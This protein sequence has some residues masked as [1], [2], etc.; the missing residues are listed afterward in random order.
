MNI[1]IRLLVAIVLVG[2][3]SYSCKKTAAVIEE[4]LKS[5]DILDLAYGDNAKQV[6]DIY[7][8]EKRT[9]STKVVI[10]IHGGFWTGGDK[11]DL[12]LYVKFLQNNGFAVANINYRLINASENNIHPAQIND[13]TKAV[14]YIS[15]KAPSW[16]VS[17]N[18]MGI[19]GASAGAHLG[20]LY[21]Y[22]YNS[23][24]KVKTVISI[25][26]PSNFTNLT[27]A[28]ELQK[29]VLSNFLG[30][31]MQQ[32]P[33]LYVSASPVTHIKGNSKAT[34]IIHGNRDVVVPQQQAVDLKSKLDLHKVPN[35]L[36]L[37]ENAGHE[38]VVGPVNSVEAL[39]KVLTWLSTY[40]K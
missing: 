34:L 21:T 38:D 27:F 36:Y 31:T 24:D 17:P 9:E 6:L 39:S 4:P 22:A 10:L 40:I 37:V 3:L 16:H 14:A 28:G 35:E 5:E 26:G 18:Q 11:K 2:T 15:S 33:A 32:D 23:D 13:I 29:L 25:A 12:S 19:I 8:P 30:K 20:L 1:K 7:L